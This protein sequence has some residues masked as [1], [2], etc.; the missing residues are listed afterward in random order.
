MQQI[1]KIRKFPVLSLQMFINNDNYEKL[2]EVL[3][4]TKSAVG[5]RMTGKVAWEIDEI[6]TLCDYYGKPFEELFKENSEN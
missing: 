5:R 4:L 2:G 3:G 1:E 6:R